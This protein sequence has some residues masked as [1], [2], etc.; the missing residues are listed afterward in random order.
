MDKRGFYKSI[1]IL[2]L[3]NVLTED[4]AYCNIRA[5]EISNNPNEMKCSS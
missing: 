2:Q 3:L 1:Y 4:C 5:L